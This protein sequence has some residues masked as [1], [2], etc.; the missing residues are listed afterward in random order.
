M[1]KDKTLLH[2]TPIT[3]IQS[4]KPD[5]VPKDKKTLLRDTPTAKIQK[6]D[7]VSKDKTYL[8]D[9]STHKLRPHKP[10]EKI[11]VFNTYIIHAHICIS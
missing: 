2:D 10:E 5:E 8:H 9:T 3:K 6:P 4:H 11:E 7:A 1:P